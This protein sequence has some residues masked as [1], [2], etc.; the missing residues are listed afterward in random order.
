MHFLNE[1]AYSE[2]NSFP[3]ATLSKAVCGLRDAAG[4]FERKVLV[5]LNLMGVSLCKFS[6]CVGHQKVMDKLVRLVRWCDDFSLS[7][8]VALKPGAHS[9]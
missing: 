4:A 3:R 8:G 2:E 5:V 1:P 7:G 6:I 9:C